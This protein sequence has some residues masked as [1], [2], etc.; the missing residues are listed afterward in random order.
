MRILVLGAGLMARGA[1]EDFLRNAAVESV[2]VADASS[3]ALCAFQRQFPDRRVRTMVFDAA[4]D[5]EVTH[6][7]GKVDGVFCSVH[8]GFNVGFTEAAIATR[9][10]MVD[11]GGN[12]DVVNTQ[13]A[14]AGQAAAAGVTVIPDCGLAPGMVSVLVALGLERFPWA[15]AVKI[16]VGGLP[17]DPKEPFRYERLF[18][19]EGLINEY[20]EP[21]VM[22]RDGQIVTGPPLGDV[23]IVEFDSP[24][25][26][27]EAFNT[28]GGVSTLPQTFGQRV[29]N[30]DYKTLRYPGH[31]HA[32]QWLLHLNLFSSEPVTVDDHQI[33]PRRLIANQIMAH[34]P[35]GQKD[36]TVVR[37]EFSG[38]ESGRT[39]R[40]R[41][42]IVDEYDPVSGLTSM[43]RMTAFP[44]AIILQM[45]CDGRITCRGVIPQEVA[46]PG[47]AF[48]EELGRRR[49]QIRG[50]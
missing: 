46:V 32:M 24:V 17:A 44:A 16:R 3:D 11:L 18:S 9:T 42:D 8:Y 5:D 26:T 33:I 22:L 15:D 27:L 12:N 41:W 2:V 37:V 29:R 43:M 50:M 19:V 20:V 14:M 49:I 28:S 10:N 1:V 48:A 40:E 38:Q 47:A 23:E 13:L 7:M 36:R 31:A 30:L 39:R 34:V 35:L 21:P 4:D 25:G 6:L 45:I